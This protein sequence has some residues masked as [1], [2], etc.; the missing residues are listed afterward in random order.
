MDLCFPE[1]IRGL[2]LNGDE[3]ILNTTDWLRYGEITE[4]RWSHQQTKAL[5]RIRAL[6][7]TVGLAMADQW[8]T[9]G[10]FT[11]FGHSCIV[12]PSGRILAGLDEGEG[13]VVHETGM[14][15]LNEWRQIATYLEDHR[16]KIELYRGMGLLEESGANIPAS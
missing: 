7:N 13:V 15:N 1:Y 10:P 6:E 11:K 8:G 5:A 4:W 16:D 2:V 12:S 9:E 14:E 3:Y